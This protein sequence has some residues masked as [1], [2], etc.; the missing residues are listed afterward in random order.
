MSV[1]LDLE[2]AKPIRVRRLLPTIASV[3]TDL[4]SV[5]ELPAV[6]LER[7]EGG[8]RFPV[9]DD[10]IGSNGAPFLLLSLAGE[11][12]SIGIQSSAEYITVTIFGPPSNVQS[13][14]CA[15]TAIVLAMELKAAIVDARRFFGDEVYSSPEVMLRRLKVAVPQQSHTNAA[16][17]INFGPGGQPWS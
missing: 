4:L 5:P 16:E 6:V 17:R 11:L 15:A 9:D 14:L 10:Q 2:P 7:L 1:D 13:A 3:L 12:E 8:Q